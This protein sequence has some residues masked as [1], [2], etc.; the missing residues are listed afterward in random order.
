MENYEA[1]F[2][3]LELVYNKVCN[4]NKSISSIEELNKAIEILSRNAPW[5]MKSYGKCLSELE[6]LLFKL[7]DKRR[8]LREIDAI[9]EE[10]HSFL[11]EAK[12]ICKKYM[13]PLKEQRYSPS[14]YTTQYRKEHYKQLNVDLFPEDKEAF[15]KAVEYNGDKIKNVLR[16]FI[17]VYIAETDK[18]RKEEKQGNN[19]T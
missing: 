13:D 2:Y 10:N 18:K 15:V 6:S 8:V 4:A 17:L 16:T 7:N 19:N 5:N 12:E 14:K 11:E 9:L 3:Q 1:E